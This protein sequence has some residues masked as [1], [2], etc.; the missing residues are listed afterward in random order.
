M[1]GIIVTPNGDVWT[2]DFEKDQVV[3]L[4]KGDPS[5]VKFFCRSTG[6]RPNKDSP[7]KLNGPFHLAIDQQD[8]IWITNA[9]GDTVTRFSASDPS[10][11]EVLPTGGHSGKGMAIDSQ[12]NAWITNTLG[13]GLDLV[14]KLRLLELKLTGQMSQFH[15]VVFDYLNGNPALGSISMLRPDGTPAQG[16]PF[17]G[18]GTWYP[19]LRRR[20]LDRTDSGPLPLARQPLTFMGSHPPLSSGRPAPGR[21]VRSRRVGPGTT[22]RRSDHG[23]PRQ[24]PRTEWKSRIARP[25]T[26]L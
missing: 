15:R 1:Q 4:P 12:G 7:C 9:V 23:W 25:A 26:L 13:T 20:F 24:V 3:Y 14:M 17:H 16:S 18:G 10:N 6:G 8:R 21:W 2:L 11:V 5:Q 22:K 19:L